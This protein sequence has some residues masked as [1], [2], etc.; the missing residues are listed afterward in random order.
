MVNF[1]FY[2]TINA[3]KSKGTVFKKECDILVD[4]KKTSKL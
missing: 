2:I 1:L 4:P 3:F